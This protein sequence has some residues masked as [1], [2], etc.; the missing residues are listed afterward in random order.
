M[1]IFGALLLLFAAQ[2]IIVN[3]A[4]LAQETSLTGVVK[5]TAGDPLPN[6]QVSIIDRN[7]E[8]QTTNATTDANGVYSFFGISSSSNYDIV[9][10]DPNQ[11]YA[12]AKVNRGI[13]H[14]E[15]ATQDFVLKVGARISGSVTN[16]AN[17]PLEGMSVS[18]SDDP[19]WGSIWSAT[20]DELG[21]YSIG[22]LAP[23]TY[24]AWA[25]DPDGEYM[26]SE[27]VT[28]V[29][30]EGEQKVQN[31]TLNKGAT[32]SGKVTRTGGATVQGVRVQL[33]RLAGGAWPQGSQ[34]ITNAEGEWLISNIAP[35]SYKVS[36]TVPHPLSSDLGDQ[37]YNGKFRLSSADV[38]VL[39]YGDERTDINALL[40]SDNRGCYGPGTPTPVPPSIRNSDVGG[41][42][43]GTVCDEDGA[44][45]VGAQVRTLRGYV[46]PVFGW[47]EW[48]GSDGPFTTDSNGIYTLILHDY[49]RLHLKVGASH[50]GFQSEQYNNVQV[51]LSYPGGDTISLTGG[52]ER[53]GYDFMLEE[54]P[55][56][57]VATATPVGTATS[58]ST[59]TPL[60]TSTYIPPAPTVSRTPAPTGSVTPAPTGSTTP[61]PT[62][63][64]TPGAPTST[65]NGSQ[66][67]L[68]P[69]TSTTR[70]FPL[71]GGSAVKIT[72]P[73]GAVDVATRLT[74][75]EVKSG[76]PNAGHFRLGDLTF[77]IT[78]TRGGQ[79]VEGMVFDTPLT[80]EITYTDAQING[81]TE[82]L[83]S[84]LYYNDS[85]GAWRSDG[86]Q[87]VSHDLA[88][89]RITVRISHLTLFVLADGSSVLF[90]P[91]VAGEDE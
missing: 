1:L 46:D 76:V 30:A 27:S 64:S 37:F 78:A 71:S 36:F 65:P 12:P 45:I 50:P 85:A 9:A 7:W 59:A 31:F 15:S 2:Q 89:N 25:T 40:T 75:E 90:L 79:V 68:S 52:I 81:M 82:A 54:L 42:I 4:P 62:A 77:R 19:I 53:H 10:S 35:G 29:L 8:N 44:P 88:A 84:V 57:P 17:A 60:A 69:S 14:G 32:L 34:T 23:N 56:T 80:L 61:A 33:R 70:N 74:V 28:I 16:A 41:A 21:N 49:D 86:I 91:S 73:A 83:L 22:G 63:S 18:I 38:L 20:T 24:Q 72:A 87:I 43:T 26:A 55:P 67:D 58:V 13:E 11:Q 3:A 39:N 5:N 6:I 66:V 48:Q 51:P 47:V